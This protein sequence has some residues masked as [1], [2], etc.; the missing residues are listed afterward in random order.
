MAGLATLT[1]GDDAGESVR[2]I[3]LRTLRVD[4]FHHM[5]HHLHD[6]G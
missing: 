4:G 6:L 3:D 2:G 5:L 1:G